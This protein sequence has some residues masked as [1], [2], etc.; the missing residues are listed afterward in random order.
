MDLLYVAFQFY[1]NLRLAAFVSHFLNLM[2]TLWCFKTTIN[3]YEIILNKY[4]VHH[5]L[6][7]LEWLQRPSL[8]SAILGSN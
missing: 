6:K 3:I 2:Q 4:Y 7:T 1:L 8:C 5:I